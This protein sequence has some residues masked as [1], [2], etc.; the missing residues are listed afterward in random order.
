LTF[1]GRLRLPNT[2]TKQEK[3]QIV[4]D[5]ATNTDTTHTERERERERASE[6]EREIAQVLT[7]WINTRSIGFYWNSDFANVAILVL[8]VMG[9]MVLRVVNDVES[10]SACNC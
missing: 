5:V 7:I 4:C 2:F 9:L 10:V 3:L 8:E 6:R 1:A